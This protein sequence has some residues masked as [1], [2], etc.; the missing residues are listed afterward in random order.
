MPRKV[1]SKCLVTVDK[2]DMLMHRSHISKGDCHSCGDMKHIFYAMWLGVYSVKR[3]MEALDDLSV[4]LVISS[5]SRVLL[6]SLHMRVSFVGSGGNKGVF[7]SGT[8]V[9]YLTLERHDR[10]F[11]SLPSFVGLLSH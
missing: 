2:S 10:F 1:S 8:I 6:L 9:P 5:G 3:T 4:L 11:P 7:T